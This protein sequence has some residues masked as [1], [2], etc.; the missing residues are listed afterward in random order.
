MAPITSN[1]PIEGNQADCVNWPN[2]YFGD[3]HALVADRNTCW[4]YE[5]IVTNRCNGLFDAE[6]ET[7]WDMLDGDDA[8]LGMDFGRCRRT[9]DIRR[10]GEVRRSSFRAHQSRHPLHHD[11]TADNPNAGYFVEPASH[12]AGNQTMARQSW[13]ACGFG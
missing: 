2:N 13:K 10:A 6:S 8:A 12:A 11:E 4:L 5:L 3:G 1:V 7:I 9:V